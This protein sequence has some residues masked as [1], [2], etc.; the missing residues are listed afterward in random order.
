MKVAREAFLFYLPGS[1][2][3]VPSLSAQKNK[4][5]R[6]ARCILSNAFK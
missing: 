3:L 1:I 2:R 5:I 4:G 6:D